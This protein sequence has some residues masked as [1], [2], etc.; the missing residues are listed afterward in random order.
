LNFLTKK[1][2][3]KGLARPTRSNDESPR[4]RYDDG[5][6]DTR[7]DRFHRFDIRT[8]GHMTI[9]RRES[10]DLSVIAM[11]LTVAQEIVAAATGA[12]EKTKI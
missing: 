7:D 6:D 1:A 10:C 9:I 3:Y 12:I 4:R 2:P 8:D 11:T 5:Q